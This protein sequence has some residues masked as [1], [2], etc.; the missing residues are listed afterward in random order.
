MTQRGKRY[1]K[2]FKIAVAKT[3]LSGEMR[4]ADL[5]KELG[6]KDSTLRR[7]AQECEEMEE[8]AFTGR[9]WGSQHDEPFQIMSASPYRAQDY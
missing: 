1:D 4:V 8:A 7:W 5:A 6:I 3:V 9:A 2:Q